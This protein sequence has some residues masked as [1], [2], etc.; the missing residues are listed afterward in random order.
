MDSGE[1]KFVKIDEKEPTEE[2]KEQFPNY[3]G[4]FSIGELIKIKGS[5]FK[6]IKITPKKLTLRLL[7]H[8]R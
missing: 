4:V 1:G 8:L 6:V 3:G 7:K 2:Q 5:L